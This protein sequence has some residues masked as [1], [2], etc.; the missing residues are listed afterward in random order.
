[1]ERRAGIDVD[2][3]Y[4]A[5]EE[6]HLQSLT[7]Q[8]VRRALQ[9][10]SAVYVQKRDR[11]ERGAATDGAGKRAAFALFYGPLH[12]LTVRAIVLALDAHRPPPARIVDLG[13]GTG[14]GGAAWAV[15][16]GG[17]AHI[18]GFDSRAWTVGEAEWTVKTLGLSATFHRGDLGKAGFGS[19]REG[20]IAAYVVNELSDAARARLLGRLLAANRRGSRVLVIEPIAK[21]PVPFWAEWSEAFTAAGGRSDTWRFPATLPE[22]MKLLDKAAGMDHR[23]LTARSLWLP[24]DPV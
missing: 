1:M 21:T 12:F 10:L 8:E 4:R 5:L 11:I 18:A 15:A 23:E 24:R 3:W 20:V 16:S 19:D 22:R 14:A 13:S 7:F 6:R 17:T 9:A 2:S